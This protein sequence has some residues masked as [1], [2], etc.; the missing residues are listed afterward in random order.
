M[1]P[2]PNVVR[3]AG[4]P[5]SPKNNSF[6]SLSENAAN[7]DEV[8]KKAERSVG[9]SISSLDED[10]IKK[11]LSASDSDT[12]KSNLSVISLLM[13]NPKLGETL[14]G[15]ST[16]VKSSLSISSKELK[17]QD[18]NRSFS[19]NDQD[20]LLELL[21]EVSDKNL[22]GKKAKSE[23]DSGG[24]NNKS[25][26]PSS[27]KRQSSFTEASTI[28]TSSLFGSPKATTSYAFG[29]TAALTNPT[30][31]PGSVT[32]ANSDN[33]LARMSTA[34]SSTLTSR[35]DTKRYRS[36]NDDDD[37]DDETMDDDDD[38]NTI[39]VDSDDDD[40][41]GGE[42][43]AANP[44][45][46]W[47]GEM[48]NMNSSSS[49]RNGYQQGGK[50][51]NSQTTIQ[52]SG[53]NGGPLFNANLN[54]SSKADD[55]WIGKKNTANDD[56]ADGKKDQEGEGD[57]PNTM[58]PIFHP[59]NPPGQMF[60]PPPPPP[61]KPPAPNRALWQKEM[62]KVKQWRMKKNS[63]INS[64]MNL[65][66]HGDDQDA[67]P[68]SSSAAAAQPQRPRQIFVKPRGAGGSVGSAA[69]AETSLSRVR[70][71][72]DAASGESGGGYPNDTDAMSLKSMD[73]F[74]SGEMNDLMSL[75]SQSVNN[76]L[77]ARGSIAGGGE[78]VGGG[79]SL[80]TD[81]SA[82]RAS[83]RFR[84]TTKNRSARGD[85]TVGSGVDME[86][87][88]SGASWLKSYE[89]M[90]SV[91]SGINPWMNE[92]ARSI[93]SDL[94][95]DLLSLDLQEQ[96][97]QQQKE[98]TEAL[99]QHQEYLAQVQ[100]QQQQQQQKQQQQQQQ[101]LEQQRQPQQPEQQPQPQSQPQVLDQSSES[102]SPP[103]EPTPEKLQAQPQS[104]QHDEQLDEES[105]LEPLPLP[106]DQESL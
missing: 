31:A 64:Q 60:V 74:N 33:P 37:D 50:L 88:E 102:T 85:S 34:P 93:I 98:Y 12:L 16:S 17:Q 59:P 39:D 53:G 35:V 36:T 84:M 7:D 101:Q 57:N 40:G 44:R 43:R 62:T 3:G 18:S 61:P 15:N 79:A 106:L 25:A 52:Q 63:L 69:P 8:E 56:D 24:E 95:N 47:L 76:L 94:S 13:S 28:N 82:S 91:G 4:R 55:S 87:L 75:T 81:A 23:K 54:S 20:M 86:S 89:N 78:S 104:Q 5:T 73:T 42:R 77:R 72:C 10:T 26:K 2:P 92:S 9:T 83:G 99:R 70:E 51:S 11:L 48:P 21:K 90:Q 45:M 29:T 6:A 97:Q 105:Q 19:S 1:P 68:L 71:D 80:L 32:V 65:S 67:S 58:K 66:A 41:G 46:S 100:Q 14:F 103:E 27:G 30:T 22:G 96:W 49:N 38:G